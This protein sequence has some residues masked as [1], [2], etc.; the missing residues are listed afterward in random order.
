MFA[1]T[2]GQYR[3]FRGLAK[4]LKFWSKV[5]FF[6]NL[7]ISPRG[8][9]LLKNI[10][11]KAI[12]NLKL[13]EVDIKYPNPIHKFL[14]KKLLQIQTP[15]VIMSVFRILTKYSPDYL[16][17][18]NG[19]KFHQT[20]ALEVAK[21][22]NVKCIFFENGVLPDRTT[23]DFKGVNAS[24]SLPRDVKFY[25][26]LRL[27]DRGLPESLE[28]R[29]SKGRGEEFKGE[30]PPQYIFVPFQVAY[31]TQIVQHSPW[32]EDM[33]QLFSILEW[34]ASRVEI[35]F[36]IKE[37]PSDR[38]SNYSELYRHTST[39]ILFSTENTQTLIEKADVVLTINSSVA[40]EA[41][42]FKKRVVVL[43]EA[44]FA[45]EGIVKIASSKED[46][47][48][49]LKTLDSWS[50]DEEL[51][52]NFLHYIYHEYLIPKNWRNP[53]FTHY[54]AVEKRIES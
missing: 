27:G 49:I 54:R 52:D 4:N 35:P 44:F 12:L 10:D 6:P 41:L 38:V 19:K 33:F 20:L 29:R 2:K 16:I 53:D 11:T 21:H 7:Y 18:W 15:W 42:L 36:V 24:N 37:H 45:I 5:I 34:L 39:Q 28:V 1:L 46:I 14:Y 30:L 25:R 51:I 13:K 40:M 50:L 22:L 32:I 8:L 9:K 48:R 3:Y 23:M 26:G 47:L 31:D 17:L 43:G